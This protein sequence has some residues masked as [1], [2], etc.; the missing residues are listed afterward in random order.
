MQSDRKIHAQ[1]VWFNK[2]AQ[3][4]LWNLVRLSNLLERDGELSSYRARLTHLVLNDHNFSNIGK[5]CYMQNSIT[6]RTCLP[7]QKMHKKSK[8]AKL[9]LTINK[10]NRACEN[11][12]HSITSPLVK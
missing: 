6:N 4:P 1:L 2:Q 7:G 5:H 9:L 11:S 12:T 3:V 8:V 10:L